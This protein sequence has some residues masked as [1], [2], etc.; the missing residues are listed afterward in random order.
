MQLPKKISANDSAT[1]ASI[2]KRMQ[3]LRGVF[4]GGAAAEVAAGDQDLRAL[5]TRVVERVVRIL[6]AVVLEDVLAQAVEGH[7]AQVAGGNDPVGVDVVQEERDAGA[8]NAFDFVHGG[9]HGSRMSGER[10]R[11]SELSDV[12]IVELLVS[13]RRTLADVSVAD[14]VTPVEGG[15]GDHGGAHQERAARRAAL[16]AFEVAVAGRG[17]D[18]AADQL[19]G[20]HGQAHR[21]AGAA[22]FE[23][24]GGEDLV[25]A[26]GLGL[27]A[28]LLRAGD[29]QRADVRA[30]SFC[31]R[32]R[33][34]PRGGPRC[35]SWCRSR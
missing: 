9:L 31:L 1:M 30:R 7:A 14:V 35:G 5:E 28:D 34:P 21:A 3:G 26:F 19:V 24:G 16:A 15:G 13:G 22:P 2:P 4:A 6:L 25:E 18:F 10:S 33:G 8:G 17:A 29:D 32:P 12:M 20:V 11:G 23:A 27:L